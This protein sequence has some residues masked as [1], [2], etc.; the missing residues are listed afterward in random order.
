[1][2]H[3]PKEY[4][5]SVIVTAHFEA[6]EGHEQNLIDALRESI[7]AVHAEPG[8]LMFALHRA[9]NRSVVLLEKWESEELLKTHLDGDPVAALVDRIAPHIAK[10]P[11]VVRLTAVPAGTG[12]QGIL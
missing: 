5:L 10:S 6:H 12:H 1:L 7:P 8:C 11:E 9:E 3:K 4:F 2:I